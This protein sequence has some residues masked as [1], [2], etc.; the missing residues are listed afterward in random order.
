MV[1]LVQLGD[2]HLVVVSIESLSK[3]S[4]SKSPPGQPEE[5]PDDDPL[6]E[7]EPDD[8]EPSDGP[9]LLDPEDEESRD[10]ELLAEEELPPLLPEA[11]L[12]LPSVC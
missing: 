12:P 9:P 8:D 11:S 7:P 5:D 6:L 1:V 3:P 4:Q 2:C 10:P